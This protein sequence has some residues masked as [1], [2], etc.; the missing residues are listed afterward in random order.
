[1]SQKQQVLEA[2]HSSKLGG[3]H[4]GRDKTLGKLSERYYWVGM[5]DDVK[6][7]CRL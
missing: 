4:F 2:V 6:K 3:G 1:M 7:L 5:V